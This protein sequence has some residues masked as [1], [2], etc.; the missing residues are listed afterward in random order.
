MNARLAGAQGTQSAI[1]RQLSV[2]AATTL[3]M[4]VLTT[5]TLSAQ[6]DRSHPPQLVRAP[7]LRVP[8]VQTAR[9]PNGLEIA[10]V[11]MHEVP[12]VDINLVVRAGSVRDP[13]DLPGLGTFT[14]N[15]LDE[16]AGRRTA[17]GIAEQAAYLGANFGTGASYEWATVFLHVPKRQ[18]DSALDLMADVALRPTFADSEV[19]RQRDLRRSAIIQLRDQP[20]QQAPIAF[21]AIVFGAQHPYGWPT[22]GTDASTAALS[23]GRVQEFYRA[24]YRPNNARLLIVGDITMAEARRLIAA[25]FGAWERGEA[26]PLPVAT[27]PA[28]GPRTFYLVDKPGAAQSVIR[29][30]NVGVARNTPDYFAIQVLNTILGGSFTSRLNQNLRET[31]GYTYGAN[32]GFAMRR[33]PGP[34]SAQASVATAKTDS[35]LIEF[36]GELRRIRDSIIPAEEL[37]KAKAYIALGLPRDFETT[38]GAA[39][40]YMDLVQNDLPLD[41]YSTYVERIGAVTAADVQRAARRY[42][43]ADHFAIVVVGDKSQIEA[44]IRALNE[45]P[46]SLRDLWGQE[47]R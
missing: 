7:A 34:F 36:L 17:L 1:G 25:R 22:N 15:M 9:L 41:Y 8:P 20:T 29:I 14:A 40:Q 24:F 21:N 6:V 11:E 10:L 2:G 27:A 5:V 12:V 26:T 46:I 13:A 19:T 42:I 38:Q 37:A 35:S 31:H 3:L 23:Q 47:V 44:G 28:H 18:L 16:G 33:L 4:T 30:G 43:D 39:G 32:S 45:G